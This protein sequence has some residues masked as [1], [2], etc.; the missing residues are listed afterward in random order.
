MTRLLY[1]LAAADES[2]RFSPYCWRTKLALAHKNLEYETKPWHFT[3]KDE[4]AFSGGDKVP[5][6]VDGEHV[7]CDSQAIAEYLDDTYPNE[8]P[9]YGDPPAR[10]L[11][12]FIRAWSERVLQPALVP[13]LV[14]D[15]LPQLAE[16]DQEYFRKSREA[17]LGCTI[18][19]LAPRREPAIAAFTTILRPL[20]GT[21]KEQKFIAG[22][23][24]NYADHILFGALQWARLM[25][26]T[27]LFQADSPLSAWMQAVL[28]TYGLE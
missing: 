12:N 21:L 26:S 13:I 6:L 15:I 10:A 28:E 22:E 17:M 8:P 14:P 20:L 18:E 19:E 5:V 9:L 24:P 27:P 7:V 16:R 2:I 25:S 4:I 3:D 23:A 11:T 1:D